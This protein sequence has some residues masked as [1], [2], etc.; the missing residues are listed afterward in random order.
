MGGRN[1]RIKSLRPTWAKLMRTYPKN[2]FLK[3]GLEV[4]L[5]W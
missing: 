3:E 1:R 5:K 4:Y 2:I